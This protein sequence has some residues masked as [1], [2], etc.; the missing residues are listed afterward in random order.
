MQE[1]EITKRELK[2]TPYKLCCGCNTVK[3]R[4]HFD[5]QG[6]YLKY[7]CKSCLA[8]EQKIRNSTEEGRLAQ[9]RRSLQ[10]VEDNRL[11][12]NVYV[13][14]RRNVGK[15]FKF[16]KWVKTAKD[17]KAVVYKYENYKL[18]VRCNQYK[19]ITD[20]NKKVCYK[21]NGLQGLHNFCKECEKAIKREQYSG[22]HAVSFYSKMK[23]R[24]NS[25][26]HTATV[27]DSYVLKLLRRS[28]PGFR[29]TAEQIELHRQN[30][31]LKR[32]M[33]GISNGNS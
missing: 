21:G 16:P 23:H 29:P 15:P 10:W 3:L 4:I 26:M 22:R 33:K 9:R 8:V 14:N 5:K 24:D 30:L 6:K 31:F 18:C 19:E 1:I 25:R 12:H 20:W 7:K 11:K 17:K 13:R 28:H 32:A 2:G 27:S